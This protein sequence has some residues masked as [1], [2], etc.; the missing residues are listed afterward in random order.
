MKT[1]EQIM[2][3]CE[4]DG[5]FIPIHEVKRLMQEYADQ[6]KALNRTAIIPLMASE[7]LVI[8]AREVTMSSI[9]NL[10]YN[11]ERLHI[12]LDNCDIYLLNNNEIKQLM[13]LS[14]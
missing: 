11:I 1:I 12:E 5:S 4:H 6:F 13:E 8:A 3:G 9:G 2:E 14:K 10:S 7:R